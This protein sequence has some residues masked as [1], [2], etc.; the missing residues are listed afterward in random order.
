MAE[1][2]SLMAPPPAGGQGTMGCPLLAVVRYP[3]H[4][5][6]RARLRLRLGALLSLPMLYLALAYV[7]APGWWCLYTRHV[8]TDGPV[9][10]TRTA[11]G[12]AGDPVNLTLVGS[13]E[14]V[15]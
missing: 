4:R 7:L 8:V 3:L 1:R 13:R 10:T 6:H 11:T 15:V 5:G 12:C 14:D 2:P 9:R